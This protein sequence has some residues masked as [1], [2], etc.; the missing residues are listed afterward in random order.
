MAHPTLQKKSKKKEGCQPRLLSSPAQSHCHASFFFINLFI[1]VFIGTAGTG[2]GV[3]FNTSKSNGLLTVV[4]GEFSSSVHPF[5]WFYTFLLFRKI[6]RFIQIFIIPPKN[7]TKK[8]FF[9]CDRVFTFFLCA[10]PSSPHL[11]KIN[12]LFIV[13]KTP[14]RFLYLI[15][16]S[17]DFF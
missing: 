14:P 11:H 10:Y 12:I 16:D 2:V 9:S 13:G 7:L 1:R 4:L 17:D 3:T 8:F 6:P 15:Q 5:K